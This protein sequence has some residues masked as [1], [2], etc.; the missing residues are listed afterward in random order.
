MPIAL[1]LSR[2]HAKAS[3]RK[4]KNSLTANYQNSESLSNTSTE[5]S[6]VSKFFNTVIETN[7]A[8]TYFVFHLFAGFTTANW[9][10]RTGLL[11][12]YD[13]RV[14]PSNNLSERLL[15]VFKRKQKQA[16]TFRSFDNLSY[17]CDCMGIIE[18]LRQQGKNLYESTAAIFG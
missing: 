12:L 14:P 13:K 3:C 10:V 16:M 4:N 1:S 6:S 8:S 11:F 15:R 2:S 5:G 7:N 9:S 17:L 18:S